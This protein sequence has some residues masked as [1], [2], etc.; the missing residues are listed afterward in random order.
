MLTHAGASK[1]EAVPYMETH[2]SRVLTVAGCSAMLHQGIQP[3]QAV[4]YGWK[5]CLLPIMLS[6]QVPEDT[7]FLVCEEDFRFDTEE[8]NSI[9][10]ADAL[11]RRFPK[12]QG[13][14]L[15][16]E[17]DA[18][19]KQ[20]GHADFQ[21]GECTFRYLWEELEQELEQQGAERSAAPHGDE[22]SASRAAHGAERSAARAAHGDGRSASRAAASA[23]APATSDRKRPRRKRRRSRTASPE[24]KWS[25]SLE[26][27]VAYCNVAAKGKAGDVVWLS[28][29]P[30]GRADDAKSN[31]MKADTWFVPTHGTTCLGISIRGARAIEHALQQHMSQGPW[32]FDVWL[33]N[34]LGK[35][36][37][38]FEGFGASYL[39]P[40][41]GSYATHVSGCQKLPMSPGRSRAPHRLIV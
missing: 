24:S 8:L 28:W 38:G 16:Q 1:E 14:S 39:W 4:H 37:H 33:Q 29:C 19:R 35:N 32:H 3:A 15:I 23:R 22:R 12:T 36:H 7:L 18:R 27:L 10:D 17:L 6:G 31:R 30:P 11:K 41:T 9:R 25:Q 20:R 26:D 34:Q 40:P 5:D 2:A 21:N 13:I